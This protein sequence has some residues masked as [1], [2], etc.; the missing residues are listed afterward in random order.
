M[1]LLE[2]FSREIYG[3]IYGKNHDEVPEGVTEE[4]FGVIS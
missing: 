2:K 1:Q 4:M 3:H